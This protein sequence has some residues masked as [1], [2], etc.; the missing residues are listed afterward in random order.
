MSHI[1][2]PAKSTRV[3]RSFGA[4][5]LGIIGLGA[6]GC[7]PAAPTDPSGSSTTSTTAPPA[8]TTI[9]GDYS[10]TYGSVGAVSI[11]RSAG[12]YTMTVKTPF[13]L[14]GTTC[15][16]PATR[17]IAT[18]AG[19]APSFTGR[20]SDFYSNCDYYGPKDF[21]IIQN[22]DGTL[23]ST[24]INTGENHV[25]TKTGGQ[26]TVSTSV[27][28]EYSVMFSTAGSVSIHAS[29]G[30]Y[31]MA[32]KTPFRLQGTTC[33]LPITTVVAT[34]AGT[35]PSFTGTYSDFYSNCVYY[36]PKDFKIIQNSDGTLTGTNVNTGENH[37]FTRI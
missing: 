23:T 12:T 33:D 35:A 28:G 34:F 15:N 31:T 14:A 13:K 2:R 8:S 16:L 9:E 3:R 24:N 30:T 10:V 26:S 20:Y 36:G 5:A 7:T 29:A 18:F 1:E 4:L 6:V 37:L 22:S 11:H 19:T 27:D 32:V 21:K 25:F 17:V